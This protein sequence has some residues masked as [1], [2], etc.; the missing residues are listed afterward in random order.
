MQKIIGITGTKHSGKDTI[1][2]Y[3]EVNY[4]YRIFR[5][6]DPIKEII[7]NLLT[8]MKLPI[9]II[10]LHVEIEKETTIPELNSSYRQLAQGIGTSWG[11]EMIDRNVWVNILDR[12][13][14]NYDKIVVA[15]IRFNN[16]A[17]WVKNKNEN[18]KII[19]ITRNTNIIDNHISESGINEQYIDK[20]IHNSGGL[21]DL[22]HKIDLIEGL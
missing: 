6:A 20:I 21:F 19:K 12:A 15:D 14:S 7:I 17:V 18:N 8:Y 2:E 4:N 13:S 3:L 9:D 22:Y 10:K 1:A 5:F 11:R 16:E